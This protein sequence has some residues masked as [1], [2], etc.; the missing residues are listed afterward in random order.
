MA[1]RE[2]QRTLSRIKIVK[3]SKEI[4][5]KEGFHK[6]TTKKI[7]A[8]AGVG[9]G[10]IFNHFKTKSDILVAIYQD[11]ILSESCEY[12]IIQ[13]DGKEIEEYIN[14]F[15]DFYIQSTE[16]I[17]KEWLREI[18]S[19]SYRV[20]DGGSSLYLSLSQVD[21]YWINSLK[22]LMNDLKEINLLPRELDNNRISNIIYAV[23]MQHYATYS[24]T[25]EMCFKDFSS[26]IK[27]DILYILKGFS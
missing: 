3:A 9:E 24:V 14:D 17:S 11:M 23:I 2:E 6:A 15:V 8:L 13:E 22:T 10:T 26:D 1:T 5:I 16:E 27:G 12:Q 7:A 19:A 25:E 20:M 21:K 18:F 4:F